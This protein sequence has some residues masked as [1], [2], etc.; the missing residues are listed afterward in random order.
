MKFLLFLAA[1]FLPAFAFA[2]ASMPAST[3]VDLE[4]SE[5]LN[6]IVQALGGMKGAGALGIA[7]GVTQ[8]LMRLAQSPLGNFA[9]RFKLLIYTGLSM[10]AG[11]IALR[12]SG[13]DWLGAFINSATVTA[14]GTF[15]HQVILQAKKPA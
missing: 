7:M 3:P 14:V 9:G 12:V 13:V 2:Q 8:I 10:V 6:L 5:S 15:V 11:V 1:L 4:W